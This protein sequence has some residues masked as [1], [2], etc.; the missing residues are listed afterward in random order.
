MHL[1]VLLIGFHQQYY[2]FVNEQFVGNAFM[3]S[4]SA[5]FLPRYI[6]WIIVGKKLEPVTIQRTAVIIE[7]IGTDKSVPYANTGKCTIQRTAQKSLP[8]GMHKC[9]PYENSVNA[10]YAA[11]S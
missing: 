2:A 4:T 5:T 7:P 8:I 1:G 9:I 6:E 11:E 3:H 10:S